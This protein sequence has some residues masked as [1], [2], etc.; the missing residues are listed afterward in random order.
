[1]QLDLRQVFAEEG[2]K[3]PFETELDFSDIE[4]YNALPFKKPVK[5][6]GEAENQNRVVCLRYHAV[7]D[8]QRPCDRCLDDTERVFELDYEH[9]LAADSSQLSRELSDGAPAEG[10]SDELIV[11]SGFTLDLYELALDDIFFEMPIKF[12]CSDDCKGLCPKC[13]CNLNHSRC[14]CVTKEPDPRWAVL[15]SLLESD[16]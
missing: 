11:V 8:Y 7:V 13:G 1:M 3:L 4:V 2:F 5:I 14:D 10:A 9:I 6:Q 15:A 12:L 16:E